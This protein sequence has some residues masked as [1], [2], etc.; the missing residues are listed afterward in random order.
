MHDVYIKKTPSKV[1]PKDTVVSKYFI[2]DSVI[3]EKMALPDGRYMVQIVHTWC[4]GEVMNFGFQYSDGISRTGINPLH[5]VNMYYSEPEDIDVTVDII[6]FMK[7]YHKEQQECAA[8][9]TSPSIEKE[10]LMMKDVCVCCG[11]YVPEG[12]QVC[13]ECIKDSQKPKESNKK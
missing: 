12:A 8:R 10:G 5:I 6:V 4:D 3:F 13:N 7:M 2:H 11:T 9:I 1:L